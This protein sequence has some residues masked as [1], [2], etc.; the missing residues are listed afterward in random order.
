MWNRH[1]FEQNGILESPMV[2]QAREEWASQKSDGPAGQDPPA[3]SRRCG[4]CDIQLSKL[5]ELLVSL[6]KTLR[7]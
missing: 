4:Y 3:L 7:L 1:R 5:Q 6:R 2:F